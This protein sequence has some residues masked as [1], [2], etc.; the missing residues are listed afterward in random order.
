MVKPQWKK[1]ALLDLRRV[2]KI[3]PLSVPAVYR[4]VERGDF[5]LA[6]ISGRARVVTSWLEGMIGREITQADFADLIPETHE[7]PVKDT[8]ST[9]EAVSNE[10]PAVQ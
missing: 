9:T 4:A 8:A 5:P 10:Q 7:A 6:P 3:L 1:P 2:A